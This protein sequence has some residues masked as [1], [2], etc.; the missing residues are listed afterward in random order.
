VLSHPRSVGVYAAAIVLAA[1]LLALT[2]R[3]GSRLVSLGGGLASGGA[4]ATTVCGV[5]WR[6]GVPNPLRRGD[7]AFNLADLAI[8]GGV[9]LLIVGSL[10]HARANRGRLTEPV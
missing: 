3:V 4:L 2:P 8:A 6:G 10:L 5:A 1:A 9:A 7:I